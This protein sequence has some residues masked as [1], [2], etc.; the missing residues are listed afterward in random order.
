[1]QVTY[2]LTANDFHQ[3]CVAWRNRRK[4]Q[5]WL[6]WVA[7]FIVAS[8]SI[9]SLTTLLVARNSETTPIA[10]FGIV[11]GLGWFAYMLLAPRFYSRRQFRN[12][13]TAQSPIIL[14][15]SDQGLEFHNAHAD[16]RVAWSAYVAWGEA[17]SVFVIMPQPRM[18]ITIPKRAFREEQVREFR[19]M[20]RRNVGTK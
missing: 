19:E 5:Q 4:W 2:Q 7:Y 6:R 3:G 15:V 10:S 11:F 16:S 9:T 8:G 20:L 12:N 1:V 13:P 17:K 14:D 18:Y